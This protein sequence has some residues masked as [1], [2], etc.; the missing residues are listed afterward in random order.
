MQAGYRAPKKAIRSADAVRLSGRR[1]GRNRK[2][3]IPAGSA[4]SQTPRMHGNSMHGNQEL[5]VLPAAVRKRRA[6]EGTG[7]HASYARRREVGLP[8]S[9]GESSEQR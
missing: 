1:H 7:R 6:G 9:T 5:P 4:G 3:E 8:R 2:R